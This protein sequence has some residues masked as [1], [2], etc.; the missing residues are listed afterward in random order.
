MEAWLRD[1][2]VEDDDLKEAAEKMFASGF[3]KAS[4]LLG[5]TA[6]RLETFAGI[7]F[8]LAQEISNYVQQ[9]QKLCLFELEFR[10]IPTGSSGTPHIQ[11]DLPDF[12]V[13]N[14]KVLAMRE[15]NAP[16]FQRFT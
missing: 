6:D 14:L 7:P 2:G 15:S 13:H 3:T 8:P 4:R 12:P 1:R 16:L 11:Q 5:V 10:N 9:Q